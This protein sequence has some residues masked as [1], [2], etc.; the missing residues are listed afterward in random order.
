MQVGPSFRP[1]GGVGKTTMA[2][3]LGGFAATPGCACCCWTWTCS[4]RCRATSRWPTPAGIYEMLM[5]AR[6]EQLVSHTAIEQLDLVLSNDDR[7][8]CNAAAARARWQIEA[9]PPRPAAAHAACLPEMAVLASNLALSPVT[10]EILAARRLRR[11][12]EDIAPYRHLGMNRRRCT[13]INRIASVS[14]MR[15]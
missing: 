5:G 7:A 6:V 14:S 11:L 4:P 12:I 2:A 8:S 10:P 9:A 15:G 13:S 1:K 3:N